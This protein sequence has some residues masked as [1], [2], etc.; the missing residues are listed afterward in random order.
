MNKC[1]ARTAWK[2]KSGRLLTSRVLLSVSLHDSSAI[3]SRW[4]LVPTQKYLRTDSDFS[5]LRRAFSGRAS[6]ITWQIR[7]VSR[8]REER[9][10]AFR[11]RTNGEY[12]AHRG[13]N[14]E[15]PWKYCAPR[16]SR[17]FNR[18]IDFIISVGFYG[19]KVRHALRY[20][21]AVTFLR[22]PRIVHAARL[23]VLS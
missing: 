8:P 5:L 11:W 15:S 3:L 17:N 4:R 1:H 10:R 14:F 13:W 7:R 20:S 6:N 21:F 19:T 22:S 12:K 2:K 16:L 9:R 18:A 23:S